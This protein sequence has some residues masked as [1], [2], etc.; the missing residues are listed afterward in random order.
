ITYDAKNSRVSPADT[1]TNSTA[2][3]KF[4]ANLGTRGDGSV[5]K[6]F[7]LGVIT[8]IGRAD[9]KEN[10]FP[11]DKGKVE[12]TYEVLNARGRRPVRKHPALP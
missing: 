8:E 2:V 9:V 1:F 11:D 10:G 3:L 4:I 5:I 12:F 6:T 7:P